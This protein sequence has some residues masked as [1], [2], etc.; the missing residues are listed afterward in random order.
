MLKPESVSCPKT[1]RLEHF[2]DWTDVKPYFA[3]YRGNTMHRNARGRYDAYYVDESGRNDITGAKVARDKK[4]IYFYVET[5]DALT[6]PTG[7][8]WMQLLID[9]DRDKSTGWNG[10]DFIVNRVSP[11]GGSAILEKNVQGIW[12]W[13]EAAKVKIYIK[14]RRLAI[15][16]PR[17]CLGLDGEEVDIEF[18]WNDNMQREGDIMDFYVS[19]DT[20][21]GGRFNYV[22]DTKGH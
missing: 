2:E 17:S 3:S 19:G 14:G 7:S 8:H 16:I 1:V 15:A 18:K 9:A 12:M 13:E 21:P 6:P 20:A 5:A 10:Y 11:K 22:Y 4:N